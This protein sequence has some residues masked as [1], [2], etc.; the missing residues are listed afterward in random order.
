MPNYRYTARDERG[1]AVSGTLAAASASA[2]ADQLRR[3][4]YFVTKCREL[5]AD[6]AGDIQLPWLNRV[7]TDD[8]VM[9]NVQLAKMVHVGIPLVTA[10]DTLMQQTAHPQLQRV[11]REVAKSVESGTS[12]S[13]A[14]SLHPQVFS[15]LFVSMVHAG[16]ISGKLD[17][18]LRR[19]ALFAKRHAEL[20]QQ[21]M[22]ALTYPCVLAVMGAGITVFLLVGIIPKFMKIFIEANVPLPL[23]TVILSRLGEA[24][25]SNGLALLVVTGSALAG[26]T[27][28]F[29]TAVGRRQ[30]D[31][32]ILKLP[33]LGELVRRASLADMASTLET[34]LAS[35]VPVLE[36]LAIAEQTCGNVAIAEVCRMAQQRVK[37]GGAMSVALQDSG[38][39]P[40]M[41]VQ[42]VAVG[43]SS[44]TVDQMLGEIAGHYDELVQHSIKRLMTLIEPVFLIV[45]GGM[46]ALIMASVLL[47]LFRMVN[48][49]HHH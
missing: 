4:G 5:A 29:G 2:L 18:I 21:L 40:P 15:R 42:M 46:I 11:V 45:M 44:G 19:L 24:L 41:V 6:A 12:F 48:V 7:G 13:E 38:Q 3:T 9:M 39:C 35:G 8:L 23:P 30:R 33:V 27:W 17:E 10:L 22:T 36:S 32:V 43:E 26:L 25:R 28:W 49:I 14:L 1:H 31:A 34:L 16:E 37:E 47:P 20:R